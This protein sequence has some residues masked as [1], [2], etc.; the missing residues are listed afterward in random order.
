M[1]SRK[2][3]NGDPTRVG[4]ACRL[5]VTSGSLVLGCKRDPLGSP[6]MVFFND[7]EF[8]SSKSF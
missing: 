3:I 5:K 6:L 4:H 8:V 1:T 2:V 7:V